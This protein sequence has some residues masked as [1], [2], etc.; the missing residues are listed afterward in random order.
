MTYSELQQARVQQIAAKSGAV[1]FKC[2]GDWTAETLQD[3]LKSLEIYS[4]SLRNTSIQWDVSEVGK[5]D[6][7]GM[8][9]YIHY[10]DLLKS[11]QCSIELTGA[12]PEYE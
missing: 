5:V 6:S 11:Q 8:M 1:I 9:L 3:V 7:A 2:L 4:S 12:R 10:H